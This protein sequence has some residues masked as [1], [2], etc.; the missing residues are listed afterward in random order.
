MMGRL[1]RGINVDSNGFRVMSVVLLYVSSIAGRL[2]TL[3]ITMTGK[4]A[5]EAVMAILE[6]VVTRVFV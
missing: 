2:F 3:T 4:N 6:E 1:S 5:V